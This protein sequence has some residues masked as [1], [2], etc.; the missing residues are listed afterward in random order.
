MKRRASECSPL[1]VQ[2]F[3]HLLERFASAQSVTDVNIAA[4]VALN[5]LV[6][7]DD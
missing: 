1:T 7:V 6:G 4:G 3:A 5:D 2:E